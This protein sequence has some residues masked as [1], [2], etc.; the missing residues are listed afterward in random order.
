MIQKHWKSLI[1]LEDIAVS[2]VGDDPY[3]AKIEIF[4]LERGYGLTLG[5]ALRRVLLSSMRGG[6]VTSVR[7]E[8]VSHE[9]S[10]VS[11]LREDI[12]QIALNLKRLHIATSSEEPKV[13]YLKKSGKGIVYA[14]DIAKATEVRILNPDLELCEIVRDDMPLEME[15]TVE[16]GV[17]YR[18]ASAEVRESDRIYLDA[19]FSPILNVAVHVEKTRVK[20]HTDY[21]KLEMIIRTDG[22]VM[23]RDALAYAARILQE[24]LAPLVN[25]DDPKD[26][27]LE[28][29][30]QTV[31]PIL[32]QLIADLPVTARSANCLRNEN[33]VYLGDLASLTE[34]EM[35]KMPNFGRKSLTELRE[36]LGNYGLSFG[37]D[38]PVWPPKKL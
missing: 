37:M 25:F 30:D 4:P 31:D 1:S 32:M 3:Q 36:L 24:Q 7:I 21:D 18:Q 6:A 15:L 5:S 26:E 35:M 11:F 28:S 14:S 33:I 13:L 29:S 23:P 2:R 10:A 34:A 9:F 22:S 17:G 8:G 38:L 20:Q 19:L 16:Q 12:T 27:V